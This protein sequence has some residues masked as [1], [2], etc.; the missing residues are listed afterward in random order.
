MLPRYRN[1]QIEGTSAEEL[2]SVE[3]LSVIQAGGNGNGTKNGQSFNLSAQQL[4]DA[5]ALIRLERFLSKIIQ[6]EPGEIRPAYHKAAHVFLTVPPLARHYFISIPRFIRVIRTLPDIFSY[7]T[8]I[9][10]F[11]KT[12]G[13]LGLLKENLFI[14]NIWPHEANNFND[15]AVTLFNQLYKALVEAFSNHAVKSKIYEEKRE[16]K[17]RYIEYQNYIDLL[18]IK[19]HRLEVVRVDLQYREDFARD[20]SLAEANKHLE[21]FFANQ[22]W[23]KIFKG[24]VGKIVHTEYGV[25]KGIHFHL[26]LFFNARIRNPA[27]HIFLGKQITRYWEEVITEGKGYGWNCNASIKTYIKNGT[28]GIGDLSAK[29]SLGILNLKKHVL[30]YFF[31]TEQLFRPKCLKKYRVFRRGII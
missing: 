19:F 2:P 17:R 4:D 6:G 16:I 7:S 30:G 18:F 23:N 10:T 25:Q 5:R 12:L 3:V 15:S 22:R 13:E 21:R 8:L 20:I 9:E 11:R 31:Q 14:E 27:R 28:N 1:S 26:I 24:I 29:D